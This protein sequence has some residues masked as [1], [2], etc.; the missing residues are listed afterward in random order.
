MQGDLLKNGDKVAQILDLHRV[1]AIVGVPES[2]VPSFSNL[3]ESTVIIE[4]LNNLSVKGKKIFL[5]YQPQNMSRLYDLELLIPNT[6]SRIRPG[7][8][9]RVELVKKVHENTLMIPLYAII[10][11]NNH[12]FV[13][14]EKTGHAEK[15]SITP[16][17]MSGWQV[18]VT[19]GIHSGDRVVVVGHRQ[20]KENQPVEVV[21]NV[22]DAAEILNP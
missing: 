1:K 22:V 14:I 4:A 5:S 19:S 9:A 8:F 11:E 17:I 15:R 12:Q 18:Q 21:Q 20:L 3:D 6:D 10:N 7:M 16:G 2:D 13:Y